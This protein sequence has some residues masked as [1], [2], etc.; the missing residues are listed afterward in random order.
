MSL[1]IL[2]V[3]R[4]VVQAAFPEPCRKFGV[5]AVFAS[6]ICVSGVARGEAPVISASEFEASNGTYFGSQTNNV[7]QRMATVIPTAYSYEDGQA[8][9]AK[10]STDD[11]SDCASCDVSCD[12]GC[13]SMGGNEPW[14]LFPNPVAGI[15]F[16]GWTSV[17]YH[18]AANRFSFNTLPDNVQLGQQWFWAERVAD[19]SKGFDI[20]GR[21]DYLYGTDAPDTQAFGPSDSHWDTDWDNTSVADGEIGS[22][23]GHAM[24]QLYGEVAIGEFSVKVGKFFTLVGNEVVAA[25]GNFFYSRQFMFWNAEPFTHTGALT[26]Y[27]LSDETQIFN[28][29]VMG[30]DSGFLD[31]GDAYLGGFKHKLNDT[32]NVVYATSLGRLRDRNLATNGENGWVHSLI[33]TGTLSDKLTY[34]SQ[35]DA[36]QTRNFAGAQVRNTVGTNQYLI[37]ALTDKISIGQRF[38][39]FNLEAPFA[40]AASGDVYNYTL[41][42]NYAYS[43]N[44]LFRPEIRQVWDKTNSTGGRIFNEGGRASQLAF[45]GDMVFVF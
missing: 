3:M 7:R 38:E 15:S 5:V 36:L 13:D 27:N 2:G 35:W 23:Y 12:G 19:G 41:G 34:I 37:Y 21:I 45:G 22:G 4:G 33:F 11:S 18:S 14:K 1:S 26:T 10:E 8:P 16:G 32:W 39:W 9:E 40:N 42:L 28:G 29:Y 17:G 30:W 25:T 24:P 31:N 43:Q 20:G 44:V 6:A